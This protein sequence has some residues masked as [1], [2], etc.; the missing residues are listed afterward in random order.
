MKSGM[1][2]SHDDEDAATCRGN[3]FVNGDVR[4]DGGSNRVGRDDPC[5][6]RENGTNGRRPP[7]LYRELRSHGAGGRRQ[8]ASL[9]EVPGARPVGMT[10]ENRAANAAVEH[11]RKRKVVRLGMPLA[12]ARVVALRERLDAQP[13]LVLRSAAEAAATRR[14]GVLQ[15]AQGRGAGS[16]FEA[17]LFSSCVG[18]AALA[19]LTRQA[20]SCFERRAFCLRRTPGSWGVVMGEAV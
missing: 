6:E 14:V 13:F 1:P 10:V 8:M 7:E 20:A 11:P 12:D 9:H 5:P 19:F 15:A 3:Q 2:F 18:D 16:Y 17:V 4:F